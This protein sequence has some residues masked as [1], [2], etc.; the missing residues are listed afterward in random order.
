[1]KK[2][3]I[4]ILLCSLVLTECTDEMK[5]VMD[6]TPPGEVMNYNYELLDLD[7]KVA[8]TNSSDEDLRAVN[9]ILE[10]NTG[11]AIEEKWVTS[12][13]TS[14]IFES[15]TTGEYA[16]VIKTMDKNENVSD[17]VKTDNF[18]FT[19]AAPINLGN[20]QYQIKYNTIRLTWDAVEP[21]MN[22]DKI[23]VSWLDSTREI[24][25]SATEFLVT[26]LPDGENYINYQTKSTEGYISSLRT[27]PA[28]VINFPFVRVTGNGHDFYIAKYET[29]ALEFDTFLYNRGVIAD[30]IYNGKILIKDGGWWASYDAGTLRWSHGWGEE[31]PAIWVTWEG[32]RIYSEEV[33]QGRLPTQEEWLYAAQ[34]GQLS[35]GYAYAGSDNIDEVAQYQYVD[36]TKL[37]PIGQKQPNELGIY[38]M[39]GNATEYIQETPSGNAQTMGGCTNPSYHATLPLTDTGTLKN[40]GFNT[41]SSSY[42]NGFR[43]VIET[44]TVHGE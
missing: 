32:A 7:I 16:I 13:S 30:G 39:S 10:D 27:S 40:W 20:V 33:W 34:G 31:S 9:V 43:V 6:E 35:Q 17:G 26:G 37:F 18:Q 36:G 42:F 44:A 24:S 38:D 8:W 25:S 2:Q 1:M 11:Q 5:I 12:D 15:V 23:V 22:V 28:Q 19:S 21:G 29:T 3:L 14:V 4:V 41:E